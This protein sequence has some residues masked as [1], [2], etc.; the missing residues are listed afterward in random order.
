MQRGLNADVEELGNRIKLIDILAMPVLVA[1][2]A[3]LV[4]WRR[5]WLRADAGQ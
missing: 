1:L 4:S 5:R 3:L 2:F